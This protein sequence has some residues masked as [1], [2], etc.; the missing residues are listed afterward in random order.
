MVQFARSLTAGDRA[1]LEEAG[2]RLLWY[3]PDNAWVA[4]L[5]DDGWP[6]GGR[7]G[8]HPSSGGDGSDW[9]FVRWWGDHLPSYKLHGELAADLPGGG[10]MALD[11]SPLEY[12]EDVA[13][14]PGGVGPLDMLEALGC[15]VLS[16]ERALVRIIAPAAAVPAVAE[17]DWV[18]WVQPSR[19]ILLE[20]D[21]STRILKVRQYSDG[22]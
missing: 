4:G 3:I 19:E 10:V 21:H 18:G 6:W 15:V 13:R 9:S 20:N 8:S 11:I 17:V 22:T 12:I 14:G 7:T 2:V 5:G 1:D 16:S